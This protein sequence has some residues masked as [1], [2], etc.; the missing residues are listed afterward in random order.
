M[1]PFSLAIAALLMAACGG[2]TAPQALQGYVEGE[3]VRIA[4]PFAGTLVSLDARRGQAVVPGAPLFAL[5]A[6]NESAERREAGERVRRAEA[7]LADL[8]RGLRR[9]EIEAVRAQLAQ[10]QVA[11]QF[12]LREYA[13]QEDLVAKGFVSRQSADE[14]RSAR[15]RDR[16]RVAQLEAELATARAGARPDA[17]QASEAEVAAA[18]AALAQAD[19]RLRQKTVASTV[20]GAVTDTLF[21]QGEWVPAGMPVVTVLPPGNVKV[22]FYVPEPRLGGLRLGQEVAFACDGCE[23]GLSARIAFISPQA[24]FT[25]PVLYTRESRAKLVYL[26]EAAPDPARAARLHPGQPVD[27]TLP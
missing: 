10:A 27:V 26:V 16:G 11:A 20:A 13:R 23:A 14:A 25:P 4:A 19:W 5:E 7:Q 8:R 6:E 17:I 3:Y 1:K 24:E 18:R 15:D 21:A 2:E 9:S 12:S 22:R